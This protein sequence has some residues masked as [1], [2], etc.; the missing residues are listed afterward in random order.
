MGHRGLSAS[1]GSAT[2]CHV[3][4]VH[5][6]LLPLTWEAEASQRVWGQGTVKCREQSQA[7]LAAKRC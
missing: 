7:W 1:S 4:L 6:P 3:T 5:G 2:F